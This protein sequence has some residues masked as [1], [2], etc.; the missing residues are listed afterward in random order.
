MPAPTIR[1]QREYYVTFIVAAIAIAVI[2]GGFA[3]FTGLSVQADPL[4]IEMAKTA[5]RQSDV[6]DADV[7]LSPV[8][9]M[10]DES[11]M[12]YIDGKAV[13]VVALKRHLDQNSIEYGTEIKDLGQDNVQIIN[14]REHLRVN[15][16]EYVSL[17]YLQ[18]GTV[19]L[20]RVEF[21]RGDAL[22]EAVFSME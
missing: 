18:P 4:S 14:L 17:E 11:L 7:L 1:A 19:H 22:A 12:I 21:S 2:V 13:G 8:T 15:L 20:L 6:F 9:F 10:A 3:S 5:F 16:A